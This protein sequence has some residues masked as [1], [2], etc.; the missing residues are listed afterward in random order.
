MGVLT[1][2]EKVV[3][4]A[5][6]LYPRIKDVAFH[7][8]H[9]DKYAKTREKFIH[10]GK[11]QLRPFSREAI[12]QTLYRLRLRQKEARL[13]INTLLPLRNKNPYLNRL[14][15]PKERMKLESNDDGFN[16]EMPKDTILSEVIGEEKKP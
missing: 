11:P 3:L 15:T 6:L 5:L 14:L 16:V 4:D 2:K 8:E 9:D 7:L 12:Y 10:P 1:D 13:L